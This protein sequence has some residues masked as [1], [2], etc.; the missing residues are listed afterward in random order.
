MG[1]WAL[2]IAYARPLPRVGC[3]TSPD[4]AVHCTGGGLGLHQAPHVPV[5]VER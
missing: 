3:L 1:A 5:D 2:G 4:Q